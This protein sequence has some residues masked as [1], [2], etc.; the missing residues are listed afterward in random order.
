MKKC[1]NCGAEIPEKRLN[2]FPNTNICSANCVEEIKFKEQITKDSIIQSKIKED[3][4]KINELSKK[5][6]TC[7]VA[8]NKLKKNEITK[9]DYNKEF[10]RFTWW[11]KEKIEEMGGWLTCN[12]GELTTCKSCGKPSIVFW[13]KKNVYFISCS[14]YTNGCKWNVW[15][16]TF[17]NK[18]E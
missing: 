2:I 11:I 18:N 12:P 9:D 10:K 1:N 8:F 13:S 17:K 3:I 7:I 4:N 16:W 6:D 5:K 14:D 15:P